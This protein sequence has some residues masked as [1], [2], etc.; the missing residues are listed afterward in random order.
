MNKQIRFEI[1]GFVDSQGKA[2]IYVI[3]HCFPS[4]TQGH[5][6]FQHS[7]PIEQVKALA[8]VF[9]SRLLKPKEPE[10]EIAAALKLLAD[11]GI[12]VRPRFFE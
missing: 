7:G 5:N 11:K 6:I 2:S 9:A 10:N 3:D 12:T 1:T 8:L 4:D